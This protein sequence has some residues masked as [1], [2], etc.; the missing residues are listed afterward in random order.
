VFRVEAWSRGDVL[1][2]VLPF[3]E[4]EDLSQ[5]DGVRRQAIFV[6]R[7]QPKVDPGPWEGAPHKLLTS[8]YDMTPRSDHQRDEN[9]EVRFR[10][11]IH[12]RCLGQYHGIQAGLGRGAPLGR[13]KVGRHWG[14]PVLSPVAVGRRICTRRRAGS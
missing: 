9:S 10:C 5:I 8:W 11:L 4:S 7:L 6:E 2:R 14:N 13:V 3:M 12:S 1:V